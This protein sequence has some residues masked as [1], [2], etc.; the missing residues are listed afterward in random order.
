MTS[1]FNIRNKG[2]NSGNGKIACIR[3]ALLLIT[4]INARQ[5]I[6]TSNSLNALESNQRQYR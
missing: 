3:L 4:I 6:K 5:N 2:S 1:L